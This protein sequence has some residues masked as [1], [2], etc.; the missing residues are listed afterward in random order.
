LKKTI[1]C[2]CGDF[3]EG[4]TFKDYIPTSIGPSTPTFGHTGCGLIFDLVDGEL[5]KRFS[6]RVQLKGIAMRFAEM[7]KMG[8]EL[9]GLFLLEVDRLKSRGNLSDI[10]ILIAAH[11]AIQEKSAAA[12]DGRQKE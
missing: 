6:S 12:E 9:V 4:H 8:D 1:L 10:D 2:E 5:P 7:N 3:V 11:K